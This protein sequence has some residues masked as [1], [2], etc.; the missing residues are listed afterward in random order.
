M[1]LIITESQKKMLEEK[2][3]FHS[4]LIKKIPLKGY[5]LFTKKNIDEGRRIGKLLTKEAG[6]IG[7]KINEELYETDLIGRYI[8]HSY[9]P[10]S[11]VEIIDGEF[12]LNSIKSISEGDEITVDYS[13]VEDLLGVNRNTYLKDNFVD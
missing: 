4:F 8:N 2:E 7:R 3:V 12:Y 11:K 6:E 13:E 5:S 1:K 9:D 10:N